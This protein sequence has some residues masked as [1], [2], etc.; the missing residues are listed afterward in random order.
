MSP[1][2]ALP[3]QGAVAPNAPASGPLANGPGLHYYSSDD[4][5]EHVPDL[6]W[7]QNL[8]VYRRMG[9]DGQ[10]KAVTGAIESPV[11]RFAWALDPNGA[12]DATVE[13]IAEDLGLPRMGERDRAR[14]RGARALLWSHHLRDALRALR[15]GHYAF[16][17]VVPA[18]GG[19]NRLAALSPR[20]PLTIDRWDVA[21]DGALIG[22]AQTV[23]GKEQFIP[24]AH[25]AVYTWEREGANWKGESM[26]RSLYR[27]WRA[28]DTLLRIDLLKNER[29]GMGVPTPH[30][31][32]QSVTP[33]QIK[34]AERI[35]SQWRAGENASATMPFGI[36]MRLLGVQG[37][38]PDTIA[39]ARYHDEEMAR[40]LGQM[41]LQLGQT[42][43]GSRALGDTFADLALNA[44]EG[45]AS[46]IADTATEQ[47]VE[48]LVDLNEGPDA[49]APR[50]VWEHVEDPELAV[51]DL[52]LLVERGVITPDEGLE[53]QQR[54][55]YRLPARQTPRPTPV[56]A[57]GELPRPTFRNGAARRRMTD[58]EVR[59]AADFE[60]IDAEYQDALDSLIED[61]RVAR[62]DQI[63]TLVAQVQA[64][65]GDPEALA[66]LLAVPIAATAIRHALIALAERGVE[67][68]IQEFDAQGETLDAELPTEQADALEVR[69]A[70]TAKL[71]GEGLAQSA[72]TEAVR[73]SAD[74]LTATE[75]AARVR[76]KL[77][78]LTD[79]GIRQGLAGSLTAAQNTGRR[80]AI[81]AAENARIYASALLDSNA[82]GP[83]IA[84]DGTEYASLA[85]AEQ[86]FP[87]GGNINCEGGGNCRCTLVAI[88]SRELAPTV[89]VR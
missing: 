27:P 83:C 81:A 76:E 69:A 29:N 15:Y 35:A 9:T 44:I 19:Q 84:E 74:A 17:L 50:I 24:A 13:R 45:V 54:T 47:I 66:S 53:D 16:N 86:V 43:T 11:R 42:E 18:V 37:T 82:C 41:V 25:L 5:L 58:V 7:P 38:L 34:E 78:G 87:S 49:P 26:L 59:A 8:P 62:A 60:G 89:G 57:A 10:V 52:A 20:P 70:A 40:A 71:L 28:K 14:P 88:S 6:L 2:A 36:E 79:A 3:E 72:R 22:I 85:E 56:A 63:D 64:Y 31:T 23:D 1:P 46:W 80:A 39:S 4:E 68:V 73:V 65:A 55:K 12:P 61:V 48:R 75:T 33:A 21:R 30:V 32:D 77:T 67:Q 51:A